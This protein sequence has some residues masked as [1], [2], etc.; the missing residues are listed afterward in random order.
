MTEYQ[1][2]NKQTFKELLSCYHVEEEAPD[3]YDPQ[4][5]DYKYVG[6]FSEQTANACH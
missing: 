6:K 3:E 2:H 1:Q 4:H 5:S